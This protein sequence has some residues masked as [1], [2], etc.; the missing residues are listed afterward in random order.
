MCRVPALKPNHLFI[1]NSFTSRTCWTN[2]WM[3]RKSWKWWPHQHK[4]FRDEA[5]F[6]YLKDQELLQ[7]EHFGLLSVANL[8]KANGPSFAQILVKQSHVLLYLA[9]SSPCILVFTTSIGVFPKTLAA[10]ATAPK[11]PTRSLGH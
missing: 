9:A 1:V 11:H 6:P 2:P 8:Q 10:P 4:L 5:L 7:I 3:N